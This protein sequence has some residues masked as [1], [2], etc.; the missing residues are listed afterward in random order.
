MF[1]HI[2]D[3]FYERMIALF[4]ERITTLFYERMTALFSLLTQQSHTQVMATRGSLYVLKGTCCE[5][6]W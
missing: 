3:L 5:T 2:T 6:G 4:Y 1:D